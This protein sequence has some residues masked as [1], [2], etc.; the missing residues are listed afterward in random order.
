M[1]AFT[2]ENTRE[3]IDALTSTLLVL[4]NVGFG[5]SSYG[6]FYGGDPRHFTPDADS[7]TPEEMMRWKHD[8]AEFA[9]KEKD[10][11]P[12]SCTLNTKSF[13]ITNKK[14]EEVNVLPGEALVTRS[15]YGLGINFNIS[16]AKMVQC[17]TILK[18]KLERSRVLPI[19]APKK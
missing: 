2:I 17:L 4:G 8:C 6:F 10:A 15:F 3:I 12:P 18:F 11:I 9:E 7:V 1:N 5:Q 19:N 13:T 16:E 14:G